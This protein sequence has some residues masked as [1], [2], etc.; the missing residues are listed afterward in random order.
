MTTDED[1]RNRQLKL[2]ADTE[3]LLTVLKRVEDKV[4][5]GARTQDV[6]Q[7]NFR[8]VK[9]TIN[10]ALVAVV[11][12][13]FL[14]YGQA[15]AQSDETAFTKCV[16]T[17]SDLSTKA[18][19]ARSAANQTR[20]NFEKAREDA[21][22]AAL[23]DAIHRK[24]QVKIINEI[25]KAKHDY[26]VAFKAYQDTIAK[27]PLPESPKFSCAVEPF[28]IT[29]LESVIGLIVASMFGLTILVRMARAWNRKR[30][31]KKSGSGRHSR[32]SRQEARGEAGGSE[33]AQADVRPSPGGR[34]GSSSR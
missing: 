19:D 20:L 13:V 7:I 17:W 22:T 26:D 11:A 16:A 30:K 29:P 18:Q 31:E 14:W 21:I 32:S 23:V 3:E 24:P 4:D 1:R 34:S 25:L 2:I 8:R 28:R 5:V 6:L 12:A 9:S 33:Q 15:R 27:N 10:L